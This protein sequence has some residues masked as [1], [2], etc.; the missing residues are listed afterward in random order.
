VTNTG[1][2]DVDQ[3][4][5]SDTKAGHVTCAASTLAP[6][7]SMTCAADAPYT[8]TAADVTRGVVHNVA[9][10][11]ADCGCSATVEAVHAAAIVATK[12]TSHPHDPSGPSTPS[13][14]AAPVVPGLPFTG[15]MG[16]GLAIRI[17]L[18]ALGLGVFLLVLARRR[19][20][21]EQEDGDFV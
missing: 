8:I 15:A 10:A 21:E 14:P 4:L 20:D 16:V 17:G 6:G 12:K 9:T 11:T 1:T 18:L 13:S 7:A 2:V 5:V 3:A 19:D